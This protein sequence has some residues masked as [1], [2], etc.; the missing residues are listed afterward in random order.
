MISAADASLGPAKRAGT[1]PLARLLWWL[2]LLT[3]IAGAGRI[4]ATYDVFGVT[5]DE[6]AHIA[7]G[8]QLLDRDK[9]TYEPMHPP[10]ARIA[11]GL[12]PYLAGYRA[13]DGGDMWIEGRR[14]FYSATSGPDHRLLTLARLGVIPFFVSTLV[15]VWMW[16]ARRFGAAAGALAV[17]LLGNLPLLLGHAGL[18]T[19]DVVFSAMFLLAFCAFIEWLERPSPGRGFVLGTAVALAVTAKLSALVFLPAACGSVLLYRWVVERRG[20]S[21]IRLLRA[22]PGLLLGAAAFLEVVWA[23]YGCERDP[24]YGVRSLAEGIVQLAD[25]ARAGDYSYFL[26]EIRAYGSWAFFPVL[27]L[28]KSPLP[29]LL[30]FAIGA[31]GLLGRDRG[32]W[33][34]M[35]ALVGV[36]AIVASVMPS[37]INIG[38]RHIL[39]TF[40]LMAIVAAIGLARSLAAPAAG[41][42]VALVGLLLAWQIGEAAA[43][44]P[45]YLAYF[46]QLVRGE[47][48]RL[49]V[50]SDLDWGQDVRRLSA[51]LHQRNVSRVHL[52]VHTSADLRKHDLPPFETMYPGEPTTGWIAISEQ[53]QAFYCAGYQWLSA[54]QP[55]AGIGASIR[56]YY[57]PGPPTEPG[58]PDL[59]RHFNWGAPQP[60]R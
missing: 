59:E 55:V 12:G 37:T 51:A 16:G 53:V 49:V 47:P 34:R 22:W 17:I 31:A 23:V 7:T 44:A 19:T 1:L 33:Q 14:L 60:C 43:A 32:D 41:W 4:V 24:F 9:F 38:L 35:A 5:F 28:V 21:P 42:R 10:L 39:P 58:K 54:Y 6:P 18:A 56:L 48:Q 26:G 15:I 57:I 13:H 11:V 20:W 2:A 29:F 30:A 36:V 46:N 27:M 25:L 40:A 52:A 8:M 45:D 3:V 50:G